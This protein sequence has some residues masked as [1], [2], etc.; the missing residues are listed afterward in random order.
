MVD[1]VDRATAVLRAN[2]RG[3]YTVPAGHLYPHQWAWDSAFAAIG[4]STIDVDRALIEIESLLEGAWPDGRVPHIRFHDLSGEYFPGPD[5]WGTIDRS[6][7][8]QPPVWAAAAKR[9]FERGGDRRRIRA[10]LEP[11]A[12]SHRWYLRDRD[13]LGIGLVAVGHPWESGMDN[14]PAWDHAIAAVDPTA[15]P[16]FERVDQQHV[17]D[18]AERPTDDDYARYVA[19]VDEIAENDFGSGSFAVYDPGV[20]AILSWADVELAGLA[21]ALDEH[22]IAAEARSRASTVRDAL[23]E[24]LWDESVARFVFTD[25][26]SGDR[27][28]P[29]V[30]SA[31]LPMLADL[32]LRIARQLRAA[33]DRRFGTPYGI[34]TTAPDDPAFDRVGYWR[35]PVWANVNW[36][37]DGPLDGRWR[38][39]TLD[40]IEQQGFHEYF[41]PISGRGLGVDDFTWTAALALDWLAR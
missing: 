17:A 29:D 22:E 19:L 13:P 18:P 41:D 34:P 37:M 39:P 36:L 3:H 6:S 7:I 28:A 33:L 20:S 5:F 27:H 15:A 1:L 16:R 30:V 31:Y 10:L 35:G 26:S 2:D 25:A 23:L 21:T 9:V 4:W 14:S 38:Q 11:I 40:L 8:S 12:R 32:P 24:H